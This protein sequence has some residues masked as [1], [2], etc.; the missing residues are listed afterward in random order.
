MILRFV[1]LLCALPV[2]F[3][4]C[5]G[6]VNQAEQAQQ[7][8]PITKNQIASQVQ[9]LEENIQKVLA[10]DSLGSEGQKR[11]IPRTLHQDGSLS[12]VPAGDWTS[13]FYPGVL[14]YMFEMTGQPVW[15]ER[16]LKYTE[17]LEDQQYNG[18][19]HDVGFRMFC[20]YGNA[21]RLTSNPEY[22]PVLEQSAR[23]LIARFYETVGCLR[24]WDFNQENWQCPV[25]IDNMMNLELLFWTTRKTGDSLYHK[26][27][28]KHA[29]TT[30]DNHFRPDNSSY[31]VVDYDTLT[32]EVRKF[33]THQ[34]YSDESSW[35]RG[36]A[37]GLYGYTV[38]YRFT[39]NPDFLRQAEKIANFLLAHPRM[40]DDLVPY[41]DFDAP[42]IPDEPRD[43][44]AAAI[45]ASALYELCTFSDRG[46]IYKHQADKIM[47][48]LGTTYASTPGENQGFI[49]GHS[50]GAKP[51][52]SEV[53]VPLNY[54]DYY[55]LEARVRV[56]D[57]EAY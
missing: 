28:V 4:A 39:R 10:E 41:W 1:L 31:H 26:I 13:G 3:T 14:W 44:S 6:P 34:G 5:K 2:I 37:W 42:A 45:M 35:A 54:A 19:N 55:Y 12:L 52:D 33:N 24:S 38:C 11:L 40:P 7:A 20:S 16:A 22:V 50:V 15:K 57:L 36:Q 27:A 25:I 18:S 56:M 9:L 46:A 32:G 21:Y 29:Q 8:E 17:L 43:V 49:L 51:M 30:L 53:D 23:T 48:S 47:L